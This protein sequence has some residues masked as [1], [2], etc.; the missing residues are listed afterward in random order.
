MGVE[1]ASGGSGNV[2]PANRERS[3]NIQA[4]FSQVMNELSFSNVKKLLV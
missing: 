2:F 1:G 4:R 3:Q